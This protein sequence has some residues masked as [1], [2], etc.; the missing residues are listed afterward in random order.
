MKKL[1]RSVSYKVFFFPLK[2]G[3]SKVQIGSGCVA[4]CCSTCVHIQGPGLDFSKKE[5]GGTKK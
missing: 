4:Q 3:K 2:N 1:Q 5:E